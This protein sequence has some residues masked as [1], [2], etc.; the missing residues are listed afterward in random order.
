MPTGGRPTLTQYLIEERRRFPDATG[1]LNALITDVRSPARRSRARSPSA[2]WPAC[3]HVPARV[4]V[5]GEDQKPLD[6][7]SNEIFL[8]ANE[9]GGTSRAWCRRRWRRGLPDPGPV[10][11]R[12][13]PAAVRPARRLLEHRR[14]RVGG[15]HLLD[16][17]RAAEAGAGSPAVR[18]PAAGHRAG[19]RRLRDLRPVDDAGA[20]A[21][22]RRARLHARPE[23]GEWVLTHP[24][25]RMRPEDARVRDQRVEQ[26]VLGAAGQAL[27]RRMPGRPAPGR[28]AR[29]STCAGSPRWW[30]RRTAS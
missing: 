23:L 12:Q 30:P 9:W 25:L 1:D 22:R 26:P 6:V 29:T 10:S 4:N 24:N 16:A 3:S 7:V 20:D 2:P 8:R 15:Q 14:Q 17:A 18:L 27:R 11:A 5:Q 13:V 28:A 19:L 21:R